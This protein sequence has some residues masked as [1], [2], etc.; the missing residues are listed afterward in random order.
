MTWEWVTLI[1]GLV[2]AGVVFAGIL[3]IAAARQEG[4]G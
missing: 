2:W 1:L 3:A 4:E